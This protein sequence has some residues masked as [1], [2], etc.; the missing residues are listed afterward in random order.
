MNKTVELADCGLS[1]NGNLVTA[2]ICSYG[3]SA[4]VT[5]TNKPHSDGAVIRN[6][7]HFTNDAAWKLNEAHGWDVNEKEEHVAIF[8]RFVW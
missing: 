5:A 8:D 7:M 6:L 2:E 3:M 4:I 1:D